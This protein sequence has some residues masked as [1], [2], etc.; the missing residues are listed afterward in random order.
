MQVISNQKNP[1]PFLR[2]MQRC[3]RGE[4]GHKFIRLASA[5]VAVFAP[6]IKA[7]AV[8]CTANLFMNFNRNLYKKRD[9]EK[10]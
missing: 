7:N 4:D 10:G 8:L 2:K 1:K 5:L 3:H 9:D 6:F